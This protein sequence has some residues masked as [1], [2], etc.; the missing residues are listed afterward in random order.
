MEKAFQL[1]DS[2]TEGEKYL[3][4]AYKAFVGGDGAKQKEYLDKLLELFPSDKRVQFLTGQYYNNTKRDF[5]TALEY[6]NRAIDIDKKYAPV[7]NYIGYCNISLGNYDEA[8]KAFDESI[9]Q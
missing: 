1:T 7:Y 9:I 5:T 8:E 4:L 2:V 3:L 6:Y